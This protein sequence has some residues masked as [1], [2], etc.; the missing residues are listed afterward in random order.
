MSCGMIL[1]RT[2][3]V[4][5]RGRAPHNAPG[6]RIEIAATHCGQTVAP[7]LIE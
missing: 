7:A 2:H 5:R 4:R 3:D 1:H 6:T